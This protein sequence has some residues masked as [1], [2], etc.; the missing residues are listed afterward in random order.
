MS[1][2]TPGPWSVGS[3]V[4]GDGF[5]LW[6]NGADKVVAWVAPRRDGRDENGRPE[7]VPGDM[8]QHPD[9]RLIAAAP[10]ILAALESLYLASNQYVETLDCWLCGSLA[11]QPHE[12]H[13]AVAV[14]ARAI[15]RAN[16]AA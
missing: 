9:A 2:H 4:T 7:V 14:A 8:T 16:G 12:D 3:Q 11:G 10:D 5:N 15:A 1:K 13:C 6:S